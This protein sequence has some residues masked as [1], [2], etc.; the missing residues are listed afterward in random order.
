MVVK[1]RAVDTRF[2]LLIGWFICQFIDRLDYLLKDR[3][4]WVRTLFVLFLRSRL[5]LFGLSTASVV[6]IQPTFRGPSRSSSSSSSSSSLMIHLTWLITGEN[7]IE[8]SRP[9]GSRI[10]VAKD[11]SRSIIIL[12]IREMCSEMLDRCVYWYVRDTEKPMRSSAVML[13]YVWNIAIPIL[14]SRVSSPEWEFSWFYLAS[15]K[16]KHDCTVS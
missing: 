2:S 1:W 13:P 8:F 14:D 11:Y 9:E 5:N 4:D 10:H 15:P 16:N 12:D 3:L 7:F 6:C